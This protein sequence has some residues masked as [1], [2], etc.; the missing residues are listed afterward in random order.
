MQV[1]RPTVD[2]TA[3]RSGNYHI[4]MERLGEICLLFQACQTT[5][6]VCRVAKD[7]FQRQ[8]PDISGGISLFCDT[9]DYLETVI[10]WGETQPGKERFRPADCWA[11][12]R[13]RSH[14]VESK[15][16][17]GSIAC[18]H[19]DAGSAEW[20][21]CLPLMA[22]GEVLG[23]LYFCG[24]NEHECGNEAKDP[25]SD[26]R[27]RFLANISQSVSL[28]ITNLRVKETLQ[29]QAI[30]DP[31]TQLFNRRYLEETLLREMDQ[32]TRAGEPLTF[33]ILDVDHFKQFNDSHGHDAG[34]ALL[35]TIGEVLTKSMRGGDIACRYGGEE[36]ALVYPGMPADVASKRLEDIRRQIGTLSISHRGQLCK[37]VTISA[38]IGVY[39]D[40]ALDTD[41]LINAA[42]QALYKSKDAG[43]DQVTVA[44]SLRPAEGVSALKLVHGRETG[45]S[46]PVSHETDS[47]VMDISDYR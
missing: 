30:R 2:D 28:A 18:N 39:P 5:D 27:D 44:T 6:E 7:W 34:D 12:R 1:T 24:T 46:L 8:F 3:V 11:I 17:E 26:H 4:D 19:Y 47:A 31:L 14:Q 23:T 16:K 15:R 20:H 35:R 21:S 38:G 42:D 45:H 41:C 22:S 32:A 13:G 37:P 36:F 10:S 43:R 33:A 40:H 29:H 25:A 9:R